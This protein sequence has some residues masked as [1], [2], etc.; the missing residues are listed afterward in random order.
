VVARAETRVLGFLHIAAIGLIHLGSASTAL[1]K[2]LSLGMPIAGVVRAATA[3]PARA[4][5]RSRDRG[6]LAPGA[7]GA[8]AVFSVEEGRFPYQDT[9]GNAIEGPKRWTPRL[10]VRA[11]RVSWRGSP[12][13]GRD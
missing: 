1:S 9:D 2:F 3:T 6:L 11:G 5:G 12:P 8:A 13:S 4:I 10:T 7:A